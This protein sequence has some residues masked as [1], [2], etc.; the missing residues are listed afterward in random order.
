MDVVLQPTRLLRNLEYFQLRDATLFEVPDDVDQNE[1]APEYLS[2]LED[3]A[4]LE[5]A[6]TLLAT[7]NNALECAFEIYPCLLKYAQA[8]E[9]NIYF[10]KE[11]RCR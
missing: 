3:E 5:V 6:I 10:K 2:Q 8:F 11:D 1:D 9:S 4:A 7:G